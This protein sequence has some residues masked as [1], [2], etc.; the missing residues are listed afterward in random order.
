[1]KA[2]LDCHGDIISSSLP[3]TSANRIRHN[4]F[5]LNS[6]LFSNRTCNQI[7]IST[8]IFQKYKEENTLFQ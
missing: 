4:K 5:S 1:M 7:K 3:S 2:Y 8:L 6:D